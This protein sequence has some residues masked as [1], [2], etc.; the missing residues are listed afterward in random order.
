MDTFNLDPRQLARIEAVHRGFLYQHLYAAACLFDAARAGVTHVIVEN[1]EDVELVRPDKRIYVQVKTRASNLILSD[2]DGALSRFAAI[3]K[4]HEEG[5]RGGSCQF[6]VVSNSAPGP[7]LAKRITAKE[8]PSDTTLHWP[9]SPAVDQAIPL[10]WRT[11]ADGFEACRA[12]AETL[13]FAVLAP[14]T[15]VWKIAGRMI[16]AAGGIEPSANHTFAVEELPALFEQL[17]VQLQDFPAPP[18][19]YRPQAPWVGQNPPG[20]V[21]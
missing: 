2:V 9:Q 7:E 19:R 16:A 6:V 4:E 10:P 15:L 8:W 14:E 20:M 5:R 17:I 18:L 1:D 11:I 3:R 12:A 13:P 21:T